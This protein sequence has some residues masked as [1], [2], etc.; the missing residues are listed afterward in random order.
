MDTPTPRDTATELLLAAACAGDRDALGRLIE[1]YRPYL[2]ALARRAGAGQDASSVVQEGLTRAVERL[3]QFRGTTPATFLAWLAAIVR[4][5]AWQR[6]QGR[7]AF[8]ALPEELADAA[9]TPS[10]QVAEREEVAQLCAAVA[11]L[12]ERQRQVI[13]LR[14]LGRQ[15]F[16]QVAQ[17]LGTTD[18]AAR[19]LW[20]RAIRQLQREW[21]TCA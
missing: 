20:L 3:A 8:H 19:Q 10:R 12:P 11:A 21:E 4:H 14:H 15:S 1:R 13:E 18:G 5:G 6:S 7:P 16:A 9:A 2:T 17:A